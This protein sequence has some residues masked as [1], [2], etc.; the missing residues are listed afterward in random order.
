[1]TGGFRAVNGPPRTLFDRGK[2]GWL[3]KLGRNTGDNWPVPLSLGALR[4]PFRI[5]RERGPLLLALGEISQAS[6]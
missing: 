2:R 5:G 1:M 3:K 6:R 4:H